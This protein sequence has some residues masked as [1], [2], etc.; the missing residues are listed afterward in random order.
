VDLATLRALALLAAF[1][2]LLFAWRRLEAWLERRRA[3]GRAR[4]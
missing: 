4:S 2:V 1:F 3:A